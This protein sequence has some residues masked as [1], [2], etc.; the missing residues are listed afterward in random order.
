MQLKNV[1]REKKGDL[2]GPCN[3]NEDRHQPQNKL[4]CLIDHKTC[5][6]MVYFTFIF[7]FFNVSKQLLFQYWS[8]KR[9]AR[10]KKETWVGGVT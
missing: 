9:V 8:K 1:S 4:Y 2:G 7:A 6:V 5:V 3:L 10:R